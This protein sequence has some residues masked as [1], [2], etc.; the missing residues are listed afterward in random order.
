MVWWPDYY[1]YYYYY[2]DGDDVPDQFAKITRICVVFVTQFS[3]YLTRRADKI[4]EES[5]MLSSTY[6][7]WI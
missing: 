3:R 6:L 4:A 5:I 7:D 2:Y 1:Y